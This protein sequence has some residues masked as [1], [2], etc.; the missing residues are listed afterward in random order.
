[1][2]S[3]PAGTLQRIA[4]ASISNI[5]CNRQLHHNHVCSG[6]IVPKYQ[7][8]SYDRQPQPQYHHALSTTPC[9]RAQQY[10]DRACASSPSSFCFHLIGISRI[11]DSIV[12]FHGLGNFL[13][14]W[15]AGFDVV[16]N[17]DWCIS[18]FIAVFLASSFPISCVPDFHGIGI[19]MAVPLATLTSPVAS[20]HIVFD[21][22]T[23]LDDSSRQRIWRGV[24]GSKIV[25]SYLEHML[26]NK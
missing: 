24:P 13:F 15:G 5:A 17:I 12:T 21:F 14:S 22:V 26:T 3:S 2:C 25:C 16:G 19:S 11:H 1:M 18:T 4:N 7:L 9:N 10:Q 20:V 23:T 8:L 6:H